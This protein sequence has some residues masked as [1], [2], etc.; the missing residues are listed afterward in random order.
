MANYLHLGEKD[1]DDPHSE[2]CMTQVPYLRWLFE[3]DQPQVR[4][5]F[6]DEAFRPRER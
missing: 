4:H 6:V 5:R 2:G 3:L 1:N